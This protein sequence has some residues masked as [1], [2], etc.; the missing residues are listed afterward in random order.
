[1]LSKLIFAIWYV[2]A[3]KIVWKNYFLYLL[4]KTMCNFPSLYLNTHCCLSL[5]LSLSNHCLR[6]TTKC[7]FS[8][9]KEMKVPVS[10]LCLE[11]LCTDICFKWTLFT[12]ILVRQTSYKCY[13]CNKLGNMFHP[14]FRNNKMYCHLAIFINC[15]ESKTELMWNYN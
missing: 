15:G 2:L 9:L 8:I 10:P 1:M 3:D 14:V 5:S 13:L 12:Y 7:D 4:Y 11:T 6:A